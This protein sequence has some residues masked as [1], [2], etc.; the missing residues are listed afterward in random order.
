MDVGLHQGAQCRIYQPV[1]LNTAPAVEGIGDNGHLEVAHTVAGTSV[2]G[3]KVALVSHLEIRRRK[4][5]RE[6]LLDRFDTGVGHG[7]TRL[8]GFTE[9]LR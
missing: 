7:N 8:N 2:P 6:P 9:T 3:V 5:R 4:F 1:T